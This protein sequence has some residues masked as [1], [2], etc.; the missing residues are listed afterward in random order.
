MAKDKAAARIIKNK[1]GKGEVMA[2]PTQPK[3]SDD[4]QIIPKPILLPQ[5]NKPQPILEAGGAVKPEPITPVTKVAQPTT[6]PMAQQQTQQATSSAITPQ[7]FAA[8]IN[9]AKLNK[10]QATLQEQLLRAREG[11]DVARTGVTEQASEQRRLQGIQ[12]RQARSGLEKQLAVGGLATSGARSQRELTQNI[13]TQGALGRIGQVEQQQLGQIGRDLT[14]AERGIQ[15]AETQAQADREIADLTS[16]YNLGREEAQRAWQSKESALDRTFTLNRDEADRVFTLQ[17]DEALA[18]T[19]EQRDARLQDYSIQMANINAQLQEARAQRDFD[20][21]MELQAMQ[22]EF[23]LGM[24]AYRNANDMIKLGSQQEFQ[25]G[26]SELDRAFTEKRDEYARLTD[27]QRQDRQNQFTLDLRD[28]DAQIQQARDINNANLES[29]LMNQKAEINKELEAIS[30]ANRI[31]QIGFQGQQQ[32]QTAEFKAGLEGQPGQTLPI[33]SARRGITNL[34][35][36]IPLE[37]NFGIP[38]QG[39][40]LEAAQRQRRV[41]A[42]DQ[43]IG[44][45]SQTQIDDATADRLQ[46]E[47]GLSEEEMDQAVN[48]LTN[49]IENNLSPSTTNT[50]RP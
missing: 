31:N 37:S 5:Q 49:P 23:A 19:Q 14:Q 47:Y 39:A 50:I 43:I 18:A 29:Q 16:K 9:Q 45:L 13:L 41:A 11:A 7:E 2:L 34:V 4:S 1:L 36:R 8:K 46:I 28:V 35:D 17:R 30:A 6:Q 44:L 15:L 40:E 33:D 42:A 27:L 3:M 20:R 12:D 21:T 48:R 24:E 26:Q 22:E 38:L 25:A 32:R 10:T